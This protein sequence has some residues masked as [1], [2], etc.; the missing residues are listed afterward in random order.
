M[1]LRSSRVRSVLSL[2]ALAG[3]CAIQQENVELK[4][5]NPPPVDCSTADADIKLLQHEKANVEQ[6][7][8]EG[9]TAMTPEGVIAGV[10]IGD[11]DTKFRVASGDY[12]KM[13]DDRIA[14]IKKTCGIQ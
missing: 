10:L 9:V 12:N 5:Q 8:L 11:E 13:L 14:L 1:I 2:L 4:L 6:R 7:I 3:A